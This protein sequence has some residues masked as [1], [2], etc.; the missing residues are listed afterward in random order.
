MTAT[1]NQAYA[2]LSRWILL[3]LLGLYTIYNLGPILWLMISSLKSRADLFAMP[4]KLVF[5]P[6]FS[7]YQ[8][9]FGV[10][11]ARD[12][13]SSVGVFDSLMTSVFVSTVG[14]TVAVFLGTLA[15]YVCSR[16][17]FRGK[18]DFMFFV[19]ST[20]MLPPVA[21]L[22]FYH[23]MF[24]RLGLADTWLGL[25]LIAV[26][27]NVGL[28]TW[29]MKGFF[30]GV[31]KEVEQ[32]AI[33]NGYSRIY[34]FLRLVLPMVKGGIAATAG[35]CFIFAWNEF[36]FASILTTTRAKTLPVKISTASGA[37]GIEW[38]QICA[39]GVVLII[40]VLVF[41]YLIRR[42]LLMGM[43]FGVLGRR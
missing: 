16:F 11:A 17:E 15:G 32:I 34:A 2:H 24:A 22:V 43:T 26:F 28:A 41:F 10:G 42:H 35:F 19:L 27:V 23:M 12:S 30:D 7:G 31:P 1:R 39:A 21:V 40:P 38:T 36:A 14:T 8:S 20:R 3:V 5:E 9:V 13:A 29:I 25:V 33:V 37:T 4:P 18:G 6:D